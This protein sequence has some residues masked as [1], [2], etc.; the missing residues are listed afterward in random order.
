M[1]VFEAQVTLLSESDF[2]ESAWYLERY[3]DVSAAGLTAVE[4][5]LKF[6][7]LMGRDPGP[8]FS[9]VFYQKQNRDVDP[10]VWNPLVHFLTFGIQEGR[11]PTP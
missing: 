4:H 5:Y 11:Q 3:P 8:Q 2:M 9:T 1:M 7:A 6:G 10:E